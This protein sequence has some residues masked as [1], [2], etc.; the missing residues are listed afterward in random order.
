MRVGKGR[1]VAKYM[2]VEHYMYRCTC[3]IPYT[4]HKMH[5]KVNWTFQA[6]MSI[7]NIIF[8]PILKF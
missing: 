5:V 8:A 7:I 1:Q 2:H 3:T 6:F 4:Y